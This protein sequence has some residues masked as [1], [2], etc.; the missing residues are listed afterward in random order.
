MHHPIVLI[1]SLS[2]EGAGVAGMSKDEED[3]DNSF[4]TGR[5]MWLMTLITALPLYGEKNSYKTQVRF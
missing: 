1:I 5:A 2:S 4:R 3:K